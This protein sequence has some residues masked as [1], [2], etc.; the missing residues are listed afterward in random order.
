MMA[1]ISQQVVVLIATALAT[2]VAVLE[3]VE[4]VSVIATGK[5]CPGRIRNL[6]RV[7]QHTNSN[8]FSSL[9]HRLLQQV[10]LEVNEACQDNVRMQTL[11]VTNTF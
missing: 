7:P 4:S 8:N 11:A 3:V 5:Y 6:M 10:Q 1:L 2:L 9:D